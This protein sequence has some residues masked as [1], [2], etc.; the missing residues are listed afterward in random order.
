MLNRL[1]FAAAA[2]AGALAVLLLTGQANASVL[3]DADAALGGSP[4]STFRL[5]GEGNCG[6]GSVT[7]VS[8]PQ[9]GRVWRFNKPSSSNRC[10]THG[11]AMM[12]FAN[13]STYYIGWW[14]KLSD[15]GN[16]NA[17]FQWKS[18]GKHIQNFPVVLRMRGGQL[19]LMQRQ[20]GGKESFPWR[21]RIAANEWYH[22]V[23][24]IHTSSATLGG[25][26]EFYFN[27]AQQSLGG[28]MQYPC[29]TWDGENDPKVGVYGARGRPVTN[30]IDGPKVGTTY[31][32]VQS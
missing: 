30:L 17:V 21:G 16:N 5:G 13:N 12:K 7:A 31:A 10:E 23:L 11:L 4:S 14:F 1:G 2:G 29:R 28:R 9:R 6:T 8:D 19:E 25:W 32:D 3:L 22:L 15:I 26:I 27:G 18:Y 24:G 20:P